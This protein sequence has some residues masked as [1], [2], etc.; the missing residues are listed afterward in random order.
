[1]ASHAAIR[2]GLKARLATIAGLRAY[3]AWPD[4]V[5]APAALV[6]PARWTYHEAMGNGQHVARY[7]VLLLGAALQQGLAKA[8]D[9]TDAYLDDAGATSIKAAIEADQTLGGAATTL[10]VL[11]WRDYDSVVLNSAEYLG[12]I[13]DVEVWP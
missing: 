8:Q 11:G 2:E 12:V 6:K 5:V 7:E 3:A 4:T 13:F 1:M 9:V 10:V